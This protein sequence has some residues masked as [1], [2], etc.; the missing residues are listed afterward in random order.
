[1]SD[2]RVAVQLISTGGF[3][4]AER[5]LL[6]LASYLHDQGWQSHVV[7]LEGAGALP[8]IDRARRAGLEAE[9][10]VPSGRLALPPMVTRLSRLL[11]RFPRAVVHS[12]GYK[13]D[14]LLALMRVPGRLPCLATCHNWISETMKMRVLEA[15]DRRALRA[16]DHVAAVS[17]EIAGK[18]RRSGLTAQQVSRVDNG[19]GVP[20]ADSNARASLRAE[21]GIPQHCRIVVQ[22]GRLVRSKRNDLL[23]EVV[24]ALPDAA[25]V[26]VLLVGEGDR[27]A[28]LGELASSRGIASRI[29][30]CGYRSDVGRILA[31]SDVLALTSD[32]EAMPIVVLEAMAVRCPIVST[33][34][35]SVPEILTDGRDA[36]LVSVADVAALARGLQEA[37]GLPEVARQRAACANEV[38]MR[39]YSREAM[40]ASYLRLYEELWARRSW[41]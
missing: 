20:S 25:D 28:A 27:R 18:L 19:I 6:E 1:M 41:A 9:A 4:G 14:I 40:G 31:G 13:P 37:L 24:A 34:V 11:R 2:R 30:F 7:A 15:L 32:I 21:F 5:V 17:D 35:G 29:H 39:R 3:Y 23:V 38:F 16:F 22:I 8:L 10:F 36:W 12:H 33:L 26:H